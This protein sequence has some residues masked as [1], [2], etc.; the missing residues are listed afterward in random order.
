VKGQLKFDLEDFYDRKK[1]NRC[2]D[3]DK[4]YCSLDEIGNEVFRPAR[5]H[6]YHEKKINDLFNKINEL[7]DDGATELIS[8]LEQKFYLILK[9]NKVDMDDWA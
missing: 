3:V 6:G 4:V 9:E 2:L 1:L 8:L 7:C 5:K